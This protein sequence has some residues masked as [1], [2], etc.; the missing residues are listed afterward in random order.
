MCS[1]ER[2]YTRWTVEETNLIHT[3]FKGQVYG[4]GMPGVFGLLCVH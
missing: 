4:S 3:H 1:V 2:D